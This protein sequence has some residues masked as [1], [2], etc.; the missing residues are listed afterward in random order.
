MKYHTFLIDMWQNDSG[1]FATVEAFLMRFLPNLFVVVFSYSIE[2][3]QINSS[4]LF[5]CCH[6]IV[7]CDIVVNKTNTVIK[8]IFILILLCSQDC[9]HNW[10][11]CI[12]TKET[13]VQDFETHG[14]EFCENPVKFLHGITCLMRYSIMERIACN[15]S[16]YSFAILSL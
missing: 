7:S 8:N 10:L 15:R 16:R 14:S 12:S 11:A 3:F 9:D 13:A 6:I 2:F 4:H 1:F 5:L